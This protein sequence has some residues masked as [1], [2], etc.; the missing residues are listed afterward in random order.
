MEATRKAIE[1][2]CRDLRPSTD[3]PASSLA[4]RLSALER[5]AKAMALAMEFGFLFNGDRKLLSIGCQ[6]KEAHST[7]AATIS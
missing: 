7:R 1:S 4:A 5:T 2:H 3:A 6:A